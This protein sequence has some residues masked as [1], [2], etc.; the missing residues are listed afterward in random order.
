VQFWR[1]SDF[2]GLTG[3][4]ITRVDLYIVDFRVADYHLPWFSQPF[5]L[6]SW[7]SWSP[8]GFLPSFFCGRETVD[9]WH[10]V[11]TCQ[12]SLS[13]S[14]QCQSTEVVLFEWASGP[15][16]PSHCCQLAAC[17]VFF[18]CT[19]FLVHEWSA[20]VYITGCLT[21]LEILNILELS[22]W[23]YSGPSAF[24]KYTEVEKLSWKVCN[25]PCGCLKHD[26]T[27]DAFIGLQIPI[28]TSTQVLWLICLC[29]S[30]VCLSARI[31]SE[32]YNNWQ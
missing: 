1:I 24:C 10:H 21:L 30:P 11:F 16:C 8:V 25:G 20:S 5:F 12:S 9:K 15:H 4:G 23:H 31:S 32:C 26:I 2:G 17:Y 14:Q 28:S 22:C 13:T 29:I 27:K 18:W 19:M 7:V 6:W 3:G